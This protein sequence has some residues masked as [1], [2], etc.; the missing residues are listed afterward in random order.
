M[1]AHP[2]TLLSA[3]QTTQLEQLLSRR[4][5]GEPVAYLRGDAE[6][7]SL[8]LKV[9]AGALIPR[10]ETEHLVEKALE[11]LP[12]LPDGCIIEL[13]TGSGAIALALAQEVS[14]RAIIAV[15]RQPAAMR[16]A[17]LNIERFG[18][19]RVQLLHG[20][21]LDSIKDATAALIISNPPYLAS[22][23]RHL[24]DLRYEPASALVS[25]PTGLEDLQ[26]IIDHSRYAGVEG[27]LLMVE[28][29]FEQGASVRSLFAHYNYQRIDTDCD[30]AG[31]ERISYGYLMHKYQRDMAGASS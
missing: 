19:G 30:L 5:Q 21:W 25:G 18:Q 22:D 13:G 2:E 16:L 8:P 12:E 31:H 23:D 15:E 28:H 10:P 20:H 27:C 24:P 3:A 17:Q 9:D 6:F 26:H 7:W 29:G 11:Q 4:L 14:D 1:F